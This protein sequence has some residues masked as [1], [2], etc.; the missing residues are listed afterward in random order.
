MFFRTHLLSGAQSG[1][2]RGRPSGCT[3]MS[4]SLGNHSEGS[5]GSYHIQHSR[6]VPRQK[7]ISRG[8]LAACCEEL[9]RNFPPLRRPGQGGR[10]AESHQ[11]ETVERWDGIKKDK[12]MY[13]CYDHE[14]P[15]SVAVGFYLVVLSMQEEVKC[16]EVVVMGWWF[17]VKD[18]AMDA[19]LDERP[20]EPAQQKEHWENVLMD[21]DGEVWEHTHTDN[22]RSQYTST[23]HEKHCGRIIRMQMYKWRWTHEECFHSSPDYITTPQGRPLS[24]PPLFM[25]TEQHS[26]I[27]TPPECLILDA[28]WCSVMKEEFQAWHNSIRV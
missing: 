9:C 21:W 25:H 18:K 12:L 22:A 2:W 27:T 23:G 6:T 8:Y 5:S 4:L 11:M 17:H 1:V 15:A 24:M 28:D 26:G 7:C 19:V 16:D 14:T 3:Y 13:F 10:P 20:Q